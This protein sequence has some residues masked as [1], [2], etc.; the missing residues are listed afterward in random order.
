MG[1]V[2][3][4]SF[5]RV[6]VLTL[7]G[8]SQVAAKKVVVQVKDTDQFH[9]EHIYGQNNQEFPLYQLRR[10]WS[11]LRIRTSSIRSISMARTTRSS[12]C[13]NCS[14]A[15]HCCLKS[16]TTRTSPACSTHTLNKMQARTLSTK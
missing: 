6:A 2:I 1:S 11:R 9:K 5:T 3:M 7:L 12:L 4:G 10:W 13:T 16:Q 15:T 14:R 8:L